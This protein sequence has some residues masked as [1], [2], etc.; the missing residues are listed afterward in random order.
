[1]KK[2]LYIG[3]PSGDRKAI[4]TRETL[5]ELLRRE[6]YFVH[7]VSDK[8][9]KVLRLIEMCLTIIRHRRFTDVI[10][11]D[12]YSTL[13]FYY[14][15]VVARLSTFF[16]I[17]Y[18]PILHGG[19]LP[20]RLDS[21]KWLS[22]MVFTN[23]K[24]NVA[25]SNYL[26]HAFKE[27]GYSNLTFI[28]NTLE[29][30]KYP[31]L[32]R[33]EVQPKLLWVRSFSQIYNPELALL[34]LENLLQKGYSP[35]LC[36]VGPEKDGSLS[37]CKEMVKQKKL[38]VIFKGGLEKEEWIRL[39]VEYDI[40]INTTNIDNT[41]VSVMEAMALGLPVVTTNIGGIPFLIKDR[42]DGL[43]VAP[44]NPELF[45]QAIVEL[46]SDTDLAKKVSLNAREK[47]E[48]F[49]WQK[50]KHRWNSILSN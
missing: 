2:V 49:D 3:N 47:V 22:D 14:A 37:K 31:F 1:M 8:K 40:F 20:R 43:H 13:N 16:N 18:V 27:K 33:K 34:V 28:P 50:I 12:T 45:A 25:P 48:N 36:M 23:A 5:T 39:S 46:L 41:P 19:D 26:F 29:I 7:S 6:G 32:V 42:D 38:P 24:I 17:P 15:W 21:S 10:L 9:S 4:T 30:D 11:I 44:N 35:T